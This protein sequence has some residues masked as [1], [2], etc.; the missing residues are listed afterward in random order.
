MGVHAP[1]ERSMQAAMAALHVTN[2]AMVSA[3][4]R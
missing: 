4:R 2:L 3:C 1:G